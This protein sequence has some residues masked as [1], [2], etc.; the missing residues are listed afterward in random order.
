[1]IKLHIFI[2][3]TWLWRSCAAEQILSAKT[4]NP[5]NPFNLDFRKLSDALL[6]YTRS[7]NP[8]C[9][10]LGDR[11]FATSIFN[12][13]DNMDTWPA[14]TSGITAEDILRIRN[15][16]K[17]RRIF[18]DQAIAAGFAAEAIYTP[19][20]KRYIVR[21]LKKKEYQE[22]QVDTAVVALVVRSAVLN[23]EDYHAIITGD[24]DILPAI[25]VA[26]PEYSRNI[27]IATTH[28]DE[29][30]AEHRQTAWSLHDF[31]FAITPYYLQDHVSEIVTGEN[32]YLCANCGR[33]L[34]RRIPIPARARAYCDPCQ[35]KRT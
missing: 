21:K 29:L 26:Y 28:P 12:L 6:A 31:S 8:R 27:F 22:K 7:I 19:T 32:V 16:V 25:T 34:V 14:D 23:R 17:A 24:A 5:S 9:E 11:Y 3:G 2:D 18:A 20:L 30:R 13:P 4:E 33:V 1:M 10:S 35:R 15:N